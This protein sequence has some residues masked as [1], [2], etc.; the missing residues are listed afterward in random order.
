MSAIEIVQLRSVGEVVDALGGPAAIGRDIG[1][2]P[3]AVSNWVARE[4]FPSSTYL[5]FR[6]RLAAKGLDAPADLWGMR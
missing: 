4:R 1:V 2:V 5:W 3:H 6:D